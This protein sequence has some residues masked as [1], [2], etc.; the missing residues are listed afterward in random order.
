MKKLTGKIKAWINGEPS[1]REER[2]W[3]VIYVILFFSGM[4][5]YFILQ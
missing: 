4:I 5:L 3:R 1:P 2:V